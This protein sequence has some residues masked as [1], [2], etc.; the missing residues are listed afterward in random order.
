MKKFSLILCLLCALQ[1]LAAQNLNLYEKK[2]FIRGNDTLRYRVMF[3]E[4]FKPNRVYPLLVFLHG[5]G[6]RGNDNNAQLAHGG[7]I[8]TREAIRH[9]F[10]AIVVFPQCPAGSTWSHYKRD[11]H[12]KSGNF[13]IITE[14]DPPLTQRLLKQLLDS[15]SESGV[16]DTRKIY[17]GGLSMGGFGTYDMITR[18]PD[19]FAAAFS[20]CGVADIPQMMQKARNLPLWIFHGAQ[21]NVVP[22]IADRELYKALMTSGDQHVMYTEYPNLNHNSWDAAFAEPKLLPWLFS[23][24]K[25]HKKQ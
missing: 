6:E 24:K 23:N 14:A 9:Y 19:Y 25:K 12:P 10:P 15:L 11:H 2:W 22:P 7:E 1:Q 20:I 5:S 4:K 13:N 3:P 21:D 16:V 17:I 18:Y 8:F